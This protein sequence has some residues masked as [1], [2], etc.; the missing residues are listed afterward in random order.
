MPLEQVNRTV[1]QKARLSTRD[2][3]TGG[4][5]NL[6]MAPSYS[7]KE[8]GWLTKHDH[9]GLQLQPDGFGRGN[10]DCLSLLLIWRG[11]GRR[12]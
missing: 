1:Y 4:E 6:A 2:S 8:R 9:D 12:G 10:K 5:R 11:I 7:E 3:T